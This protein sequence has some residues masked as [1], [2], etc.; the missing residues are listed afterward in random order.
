MQKRSCAKTLL[1]KNF[2]VQKRSCAKTL[3]CKNE[4]VQKLCCAKTKFIPKL[5]FGTQRNATQRNAMHSTVPKRSFG[6][7]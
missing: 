3:L 2:V 5:R 6:I 4:V 1:C 7:T